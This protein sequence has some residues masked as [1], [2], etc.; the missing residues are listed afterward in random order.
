MVMLLAIEI[1]VTKLG[2]WK[3]SMRA[4]RVSTGLRVGLTKLIA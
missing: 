3:D 4:K 1:S 2:E